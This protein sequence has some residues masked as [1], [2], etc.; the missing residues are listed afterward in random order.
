MFNFFYLV[1][2]I[3]MYVLSFFKF[4]IIVDIRYKNIDEYVNIFFINMFQ[5]VIVMGLLF[6]CFIFIKGNWLVLLFLIYCLVVFWVCIYLLVQ[7]VMVGYFLVKI[8][9]D[10]M[11]YKEYYILNKIENQ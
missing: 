9:G 6:C 4:Y 7:K 11:D 2:V 10:C 3:F 5:C 8:F 1:R